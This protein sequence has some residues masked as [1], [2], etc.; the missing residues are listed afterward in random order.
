MVHSNSLNCYKPDLITESHIPLIISNISS[1]CSVKVPH[2]TDSVDGASDVNALHYT[3]I[4]T[5]V[6]KHIFTSDCIMTVFLADEQLVIFALL[7]SNLSI[8]SIPFTVYFFTILI[9]YLRLIYISLNCCFID[10]FSFVLQLLIV[11]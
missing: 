10:T 9:C 7:I 4:S 5:T 6:R 8:F 3:H 2:M 11:I 1:E